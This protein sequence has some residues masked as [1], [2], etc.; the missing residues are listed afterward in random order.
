MGFDIKTLF[1]LMFDSEQE[2]S[3]DIDPNDEDTP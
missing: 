2:R 1:D 3:E